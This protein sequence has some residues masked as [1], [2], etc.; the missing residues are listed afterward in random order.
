MN[1]HGVLPAHYENLEDKPAFV[2]ELFDAGAEHYDPVVNWGFF[3][4]GDSYRKWALERHGLEPGMRLLDVACGTGLVAMAAADVLGG[5]SAITCLDPSDGML[6]VARRK[7]KQA[8]FVQAGADEIPLPDSSFD[9]LTVG[10]ALRHFGTLSRAFSEFHRVL[11]PGG[12]VLML[13][14][15]KPAGK[16]GAMFFKLYF[17]RIYPLLTRLF[18]RSRDAQKMM[19]YFWETMDACVR[20]ETVLNALGNAGFSDVRRT[21]MLRLFSEYAATKPAE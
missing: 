11:K 17:H 16:L 13:E 9:F 6:S 5:D 18:T 1:P 7:L 14:A 21:S 19:V 12:T 3:G 4:T 15:T 20:P 2:K 8:T 10:Y